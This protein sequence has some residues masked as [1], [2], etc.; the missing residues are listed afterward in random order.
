MNLWF[1]PF[2]APGAGEAG[3]LYWSPGLSFAETVA[4]YTRFYLVTSLGFD[5]FRA[6]GNVVL[7]LVLGGPLLRL[8]ERYRRRFA[9]EPWEEMD[10]AS[11]SPCNGHNHVLDRKDDMQCRHSERSEP[12][13][14]NS[15]PM[16]GR[17]L[18]AR[19]ANVLA[20]SLE[21]GHQLRLGS[22]AAGASRGD[23]STSS[24]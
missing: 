1:W 6:A 13:A 19:S 14:A 4:R 3:S 23:S 11:R 10:S 5:L 7:V 18:P 12:L 2:G 15:P 24:E 22:I 21:R 9:W 20:P 17:T 8:L 16:E